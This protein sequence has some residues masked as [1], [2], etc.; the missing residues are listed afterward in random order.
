[1]WPF[2]EKRNCIPKLRSEQNK[3]KQDP[4]L[5]FLYPPSVIYSFFIDSHFEEKREE[6]AVIYGC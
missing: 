2:L 5:L 6:M 3:V 1:M 4:L